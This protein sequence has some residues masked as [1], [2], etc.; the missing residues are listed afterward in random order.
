MSRKTNIP[1]KKLEFNFREDCIPYEIPLPR[2]LYLFESWGAQGGGQNLGG[3][4]GYTA[5]MIILKHPTKFYL[6]VGGRGL[7][8]KISKEPIKSQ[9]GGGGNGGIYRVSNNI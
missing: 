1:L 7:D 2:G 5:G 9:C 3:R 8:F 6:I 4:G